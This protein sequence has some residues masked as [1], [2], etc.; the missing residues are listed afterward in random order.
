[1]V[2]YAVALLSASVLISVAALVL[3]EQEIEGRVLS[4]VSIVIYS[5][6][7]WGLLR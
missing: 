2:W 6:A 5:I 1:M 3:E 7:V 4:M